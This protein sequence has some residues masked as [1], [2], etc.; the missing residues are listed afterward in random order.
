MKP[1]AL[2][3]G[4]SRGIGLEVARTLLGRGWQ[5]LGA[6]RT[7]APEDLGPGYEHTS[8]DLADLTRL[9]SWARSALPE[10]LAGAPRVALVN[11]AAL[12]DPVGPATALS[13][14]ALDAHLRVNLTAPTWLAGFVVAHAAEGSPVRVINVS[15]GAATR[16]YPG[17]T[18]YC[19]G[20]AGLKMTGEVLAE[21]TAAY[22]V[23]RDLSVV[24][25]APH[26]VATAMQDQLRATDE[27][28]F[29]MRERFV[30]LHEDGEL[31]DA[32]GPAAEIADLCAADDL[33]PL[34]TTRFDPSA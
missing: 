4:T 3:T 25:Y 5:V 24:T 18:A 12:L 10:R 2:V 19:A 9:E 14:E 6:A 1:L 8:I 11:N 31:V 33:P 7:A 26:V 20:K 34:V 17:W 22:G 16:P 27:A 32:A 21:E 29:P 28:R 30:A 15:S 23:D 13:L